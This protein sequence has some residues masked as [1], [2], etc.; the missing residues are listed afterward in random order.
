MTKRREVGEG[1]ATHPSAGSRVV[2]ARSDP[3]AALPDVGGAVRAPRIGRRYAHELK[4]AQTQPELNYPSYDAHRSASLSRP[5][6]AT[7]SPRCG[8]CARAQDTTG[9]SPGSCSHPE[10]LQ[11]YS[12]LH[13]VPN[14]IAFHALSPSHTSLCVA[15]TKTYNLELND[16]RRF[17]HRPYSPKLL[18]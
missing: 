17:T 3:R 13:G 16:Q 4:L 14:R 6:P 2:L 7:S 15:L 10:S 5:P 8:R 11:L 9:R 18:R 1:K 12:I